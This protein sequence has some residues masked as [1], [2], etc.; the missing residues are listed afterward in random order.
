MHLENTYNKYVSREEKSIRKLQKT[1]SRLW[2]KIYKMNAKRDQK[3]IY[4]N[5]SLNIYNTLV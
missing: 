2:K 3:K 5:I 4:K 1:I